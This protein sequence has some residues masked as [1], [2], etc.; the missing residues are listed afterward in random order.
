M[1]TSEARHISIEHIRRYIGTWRRNL[2]K[3]VEVVLRRLTMITTINLWRCVGFVQPAI[4]DYIR[5]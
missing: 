5:R 1:R 2:A 4:Q 3:Y